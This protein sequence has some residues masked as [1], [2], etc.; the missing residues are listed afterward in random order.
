MIVDLEPTDP[1]WNTALPV[2]RELRPHLT[3]ELLDQVIAEGAPQ[4]L[5]FTAVLEDGQCVAIAGWRVIANTSAIRKLYIDDLCTS[6]ATRS[7]G[8]GSTLLNALIARARELDC[9]LVDLDS[10]VQRHEAH[11]FYLRERMDIVSHHFSR[12]V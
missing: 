8:H 7:R 10:G 11:R 9:R 2:L 6:G 4:G 12:R 1:H 3:R 5:R